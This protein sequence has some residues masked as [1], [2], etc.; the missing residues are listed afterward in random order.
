MLKDYP[1]TYLGATVGKIEITKEGL[2]YRYKGEFQ[3]TESHFYRVYALTPSGEMNLGVCCPAEGKWTIS[4]TIA[5]NKLNTD[6]LHFEICTSEKKDTFI[7]INENQPIPF[8]EHLMDYRFCR[9]G[10]LV[11]FMDTSETTQK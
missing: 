5:I 9:K 10:D 7:P 2:Y 6:C 3:L 11:G 1:V 8:L 4:G